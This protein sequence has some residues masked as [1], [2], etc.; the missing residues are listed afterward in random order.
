[1]FKNR[2]ILAVNLMKKTP[3]FF[4]TLCIFICA[5]FSVYFTHISKKPQDTIYFNPGFFGDMFGE[6]K[7]GFFNLTNIIEQKGYKVIN[8]YN[9]YE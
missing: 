6:N 8:S 3:I 1:M 5:L 4:L 2:G 9:S 7:Q